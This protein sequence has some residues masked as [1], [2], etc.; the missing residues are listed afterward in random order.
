MRK[1]LGIVWIAVIAALGLTAC[2]GNGGTSSQASQAAGQTQQGAE[3]AAAEKVT[4]KI[5]NSQTDSHPWNEAIG[6]LAEKASEYSGGS[7]EIVNYPNSTLGA[8]QDMLE[9]V[10]EGSLDMCIVDPTVGSTFCQQLELFS[11]PFIFRDYDHWLAVLDGEIGEEY[12]AVIEEKG[13]GIMILDFWGGS[14]RNLLAVKGPVESIDDLQ[15]FKL[16]LAPSELK[17]KVWEAIGTLPVNIAF[18]ETYS[19]LASGLCDGMENEMPSILT[20]KF[21]EPAPYFTMTEHEITVRPL[22][23]SKETWQSLSTEQ[24]E[25][26]QKAVDEATDLARQGELEFGQDAEKTMVEQ[27]G[28]VETEIDKTPIMERTKP[29]YEEFGEATGLSWMILDIEACE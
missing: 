9:S 23:I 12:K 4:L 18:G 14:S 6:V 15:G 22:F 20:S 3:T 25:A 28:I 2:S 7:L 21:Y 29:I 16:R 8:E 17:F 24:Q 26:L 13:N 10:R 19:A 1:H 27:Y 5:G 11:L